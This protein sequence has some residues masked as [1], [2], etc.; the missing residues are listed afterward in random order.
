[1]VEVKQNLFEV[2]DSSM[3][4][5]LE[6]DQR[7]PSSADVTSWSYLCCPMRSKYSAAQY[8]Q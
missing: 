3:S 4:I 7:D 1:M 6:S 8:V 5:G 2:N